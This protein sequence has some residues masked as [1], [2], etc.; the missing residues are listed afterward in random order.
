VV[1]ARLGVSEQ[2]V[3]HWYHRGWITEARDNDRGTRVFV[4]PR[5]CPAT[6]SL[7]AAPCHQKAMMRETRCS[8]DRA[9]YATAM[10]GWL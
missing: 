6:L 5:S 3:W 7:P 4:P 10:S 8:M 9:H 1:A 2:T